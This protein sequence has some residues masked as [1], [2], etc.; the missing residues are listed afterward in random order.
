MRLGNPG[1]S[2]GDFV[3]PFGKFKGSSLDSIASTDDGL[4]Y[5][6][7]CVGEFGEGD[8]LDAIET[9]LEDPGVQR[10][11]DRAVTEKEFRKED[12]EARGWH[13]DKGWWSK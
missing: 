13:G 7:W 4:C 3:M 1:R 12:R 5:L 10:E 2:P 11:V 8:V 6:D 9:Y